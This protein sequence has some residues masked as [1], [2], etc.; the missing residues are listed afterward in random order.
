MLY[1]SIEYFLQ[2]RHKAACSG[3]ADHY[4]HHYHH[5]HHY[6]YNYNHEYHHH[7]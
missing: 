1:Y 3:E 7:Y 4:Y 6:N 2:W 5:Y